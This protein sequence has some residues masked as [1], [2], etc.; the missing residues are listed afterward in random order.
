MQVYAEQSASMDELQFGTVTDVF[1]P[2][3][4]L[5]KGTVV[6]AQSGLNIPD[7]LFIC[8]DFEEDERL[9]LVSS[10]ET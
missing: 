3:S 5:W 4:P 2:D 6:L 10:S 8:Y 9:C 7:L 1:K